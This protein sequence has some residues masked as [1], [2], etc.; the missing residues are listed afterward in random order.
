M[1]NIVENC[2]WKAVFESTGHPFQATFVS[3]DKLLNTIA[4]F[5]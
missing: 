3:N 4:K 2:K 5:D 1:K